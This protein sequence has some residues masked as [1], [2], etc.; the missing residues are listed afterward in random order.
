MNRHIERAIVV[1][2]TSGVGREVAAQLLAG[3][4]EAVVITSRTRDGA[5]AALSAAGNSPRLFPAPLRVQDQQ[6]CE[7]FSYVWGQG[8]RPFDAVLVCAGGICP[9]TEE[10]QRQA[11]GV[12]WVLAEAANKWLADRG[13]LG[14]VTSCL[15]TAPGLAPELLRAWVAGHREVAEQARHLGRYTPGITVLDFALPRVH[16]TRMWEGMPREVCEE[17]DR[18]ERAAGMRLDLRGAAAYVAHYLRGRDVSGRLVPGEA[19]T[20]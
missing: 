14:V 8:A 5:A 9:T 18:Q 12:R 20:P 16:G 6:Q 7:D 15:T 1:G 19:P 4:A 10:Q 11:A 2:G 3:G 17:L 13:V